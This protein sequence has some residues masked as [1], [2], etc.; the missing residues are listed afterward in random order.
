MVKSSLEDKSEKE[1]IEALIWLVGYKIKWSV[2][3]WSVFGVAL[4]FYQGL[5]QIWREITQKWVVIYFSYI[6][7]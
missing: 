5:D 3:V 2:F 7:R 4:S 1:D 6:F